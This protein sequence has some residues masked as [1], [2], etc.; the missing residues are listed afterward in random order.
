MPQGAST[1]LPQLELDHLVVA[2]RTLEEGAAWCEATL[3]V[4]PE[5][6]GR[7]AW[8]GTHNRLLSLSSARFPKS[9][10]EIVAIDPDALAPARTR[11]FDLDTPQLRQAIASSPRLVHWVART[12]AI[13]AAAKAFRDAGYDVGSPTVA[14]R[15]TP[16]GMLRWR[17]TVRDDGGRPAGGAVPL[18]IQWG[19]EHPCDAL[20]ASGVALER[21]EAGGVPAAFASWIGVLPANDTPGVASQTASAL[22]P[23]LDSPALA[24]IFRMRLGPVEL[25][26]P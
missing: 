8:M 14:E 2:A 22:L 18:L 1:T 19:D 13:D 20:R 17:I 7:H 24:A 3:G 23:R 11:W 16:R 21:V 6:G 15:M 5:A 25:A 10:L 9:Y 4:V 26:T 12:T